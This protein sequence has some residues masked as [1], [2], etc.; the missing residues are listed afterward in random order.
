MLALLCIPNIIFLVLSNWSLVCVA[1]INSLK[2][3]SWCQVK[4]KFAS[5]IIKDGLSRCFRWIS[6]SLIIQ[7]SL[8]GYLS[9]NEFLKLRSLVMIRK[10]VF[11]LSSLRYEKRKSNNHQQS[12]ETNIQ[13][14]NSY[15]AIGSA[16]VNHGSSDYHMTLMNHIPQFFM[17]WCALGWDIFISSILLEWVTF[18]SVS[19][20]ISS[21]SET[22]WQ[23]NLFR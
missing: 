14:G 15:T 7:C 13:E 17:A 4:T 22:P 1:L 6:V 21:P 8:A 11:I 3:C 5:S 12:R 19:L 18:G 20:S 9:W 2:I 23:R 10:E 16:I